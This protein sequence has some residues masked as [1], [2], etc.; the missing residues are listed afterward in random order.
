M[1]AWGTRSTP[2]PPTSASQTPHNRSRWPAP[3]R[4]ACSAALRL[5][6]H[7]TKPSATAGVFFQGEFL[8]LVGNYQTWDS[9]MAAYSPQYWQGVSFHVYPITNPSMAV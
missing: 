6:L 2:G 3:A 9:G 7:A 5:Q 1:Q 8:T 4:K